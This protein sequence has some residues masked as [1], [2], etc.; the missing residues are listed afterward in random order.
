ML[1]QTGIALLRKPNEHI[2]SLDVFL[3]NE[4]VR[5]W[6]RS[7]GMQPVFQRVWVQF[8]LVGHEMGPTPDCE[9]LGMSDA[10]R[11]HARYGFSEFTIGRPHMTHAVGRLGESLFRSLAF[12]IVKDAVALSVLARLDGHRKLLCIGFPHDALYGQPAGG[13]IVAESERMVGIIDDVME[14]VMRQSGFS[15]AHAVSKARIPPIERSDRS[16]IKT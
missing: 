14:R 3:S 1:C 5:R 15:H 10:N 16:E 13:S 7:L 11:A 6:Y 9:I 12:D 2:V 4:R 8:P